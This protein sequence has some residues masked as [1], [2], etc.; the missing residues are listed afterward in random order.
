M[1]AP[2]VAVGAGIYGAAAAHP[3]EETEQAIAA[4]V[5]VYNDEMLLGSLDEM[6]ALRIKSLGF[7]A[8]TPCAGLEGH[9]ETSTEASE[10]TFEE[11]GAAVP[12]NRLRLTV[13]YGF[14]TKGS[15][16]PDLIYSIDV[17]AFAANSD[18]N[19]TAESYRWF[20][21][22]PELDFFD[23]TS[24]KAASLRRRIA[25]TQEQL[26]DRIIDDL[27]LARHSLQITGAY[28]PNR[29]GMNFLT[30]QTKPGAVIRYP[31][32]SQLINV[33]KDALGE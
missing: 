14:F 16:S 17:S 27:F 3:A 5:Q 21:L 1:L 15:Y 26:A 9:N 20:Y 30:H 11:C 4:I 23:E 31:T 8:Q 13:N 12:K 33:P 25:A 24:S 22:S 29:K 19:K 28:Y 6:I 2:V 18:L 10:T 32:Q 7:P